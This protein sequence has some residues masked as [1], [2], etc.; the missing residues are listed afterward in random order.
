MQT[1]RHVVLKAERPASLSADAGIGPAVCMP[2]WT[3]LLA[4]SSALQHERS[5]VMRGAAI[6]ATSADTTSLSMSDRQSH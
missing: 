4:G 5:L 6:Q 2:A 3:T 1:S